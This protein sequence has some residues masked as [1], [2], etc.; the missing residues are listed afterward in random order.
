MKVTRKV[1]LRFYT[2]VLAALLIGGTATAGDDSKQDDTANFGVRGNRITSNCVIAGGVLVKPQ[3]PPPPTTPANDP[4]QGKVVALD[5]SPSSRWSVD[6][7]WFDPG[8][9]KYYLADRN[10]G[11]V[12][13][14]DTV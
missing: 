14:F 7:G 4:C 5:K 2:F 10:N 8:T 11:G 3:V 9:E 13:V 1:S 6:I 12:D